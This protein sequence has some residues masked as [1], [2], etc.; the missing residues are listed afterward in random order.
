MCKNNLLSYFYRTVLTP[1][2]QLLF[3]LTF[4]S[5][6]KINSLLC[7]LV[8]SSLFLLLYSYGHCFSVSPLSSL[9]QLIGG[10]SQQFFSFP[11]LSLVRLAY[12]CQSFLFKMRNTYCY[13]IN[14]I[15]LLNLMPL[16]LWY[17]TLY[18]LCEGSS[19][20]QQLFGPKSLL[21]CWFNSVFPYHF[22]YFYIKVRIEPGT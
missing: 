4:Y 11:P 5:Q 15:P 17:K 21:S 3:C 22:T 12:F 7:Y 8:N 6:L 2:S 18:N 20:L 9:S 13:P 16:S 19:C 10:A 14:D 1:H